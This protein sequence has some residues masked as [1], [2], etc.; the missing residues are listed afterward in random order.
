M[1]TSAG[2]KNKTEFVMTEEIASPAALLCED[3]L[4]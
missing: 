4:K 1:R 3:V 2:K